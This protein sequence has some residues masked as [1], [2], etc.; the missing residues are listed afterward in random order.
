MKFSDLASAAA[1]HTCY[2]QHTW[3]GLG[4]AGRPRRAR[5]DTTLEG[6][7]CVLGGESR[8]WM[9]KQDGIMSVG[10]VNKVK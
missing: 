6:C 2:G 9:A 4:L 3:P 7:V 10:R 1:T 8:L 5:I